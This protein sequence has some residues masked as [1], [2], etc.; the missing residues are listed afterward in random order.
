MKILVALFIRSYYI[1]L[2]KKIKYFFNIDSTRILKLLI[3]GG[4]NV[5]L[6]TKDENKTALFI[7]AFKGKLLLHSLSS[8]P[9]DYHTKKM[10]STKTNS[11]C[12][13]QIQIDPFV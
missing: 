11:S 4:A 7:S 9:Q 12:T 5:N 3:E 2:P 6:R 10:I 1:L 13:F 8:I